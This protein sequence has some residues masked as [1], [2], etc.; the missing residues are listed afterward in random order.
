MSDEVQYP[1]HSYTHPLLY[2]L[3]PY[4]SFR[5]KFARAPYSVN[6]LIAAASQRM[7]STYSSPLSIQAGVSS[8][9][10]MV[11]SPPHMRS[12]S[13]SCPVSIVTVTSAPV[14]IVAG[15]RQGHLLQCHGPDCVHCR[16]RYFVIDIDAFQVGPG[17]VFELLGSGMW[18]NRLKALSFAVRSQ[19][20]VR[21]QGR[22]PR[23]SALLYCAR[24]DPLTHMRIF[25]CN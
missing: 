22:C 2:S 18:I 6:T 20:Q 24:R 7:Y 14:T 19:H 4:S 1:I 3:L 25:H 8:V 17:P 12:A 23:A 9:T 11:W 10:V 5:S 13:V 16:R 15:R 21:A